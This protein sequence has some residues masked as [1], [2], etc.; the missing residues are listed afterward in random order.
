M[1]PT[2]SRLSVWWNW[3]YRKHLVHISHAL[4][5][6]PSF[7]GSVCPSKTSVSRRHVPH[8]LRQSLENQWARRVPTT[9][10]SNHVTGRGQLGSSI[11]LSAGGGH[12]CPVLAMQGWR[13]SRWGFYGLQVHKPP[14]PSICV[15]LSDLPWDTVPT[16]PW[17]FQFNHFPH[18][19][20]EPTKTLY[21]SLGLLN[22]VW[23]P[24]LLNVA[25]PHLAIECSFLL[26]PQ[27]CTLSYSW[28]TLSPAPELTPPA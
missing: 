2:V 28:S 7:Q 25:P 14:S 1:K 3:I 4:T 26:Y 8:T 20:H 13:E 22:S 27:I 16:P 12:H 23:F 5:P 24:T 21:C 17:N 10:I 9:A 6:S 18:A 19:T 11:S 15:L